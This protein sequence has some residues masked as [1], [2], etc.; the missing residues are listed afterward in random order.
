MISEL[1]RHNARLKGIGAYNEGLNFAQCPN[2]GF[3]P[4]DLEWRWEWQ[5]GWLRAQ[6]DEHD[7]KK[8]QPKT[9]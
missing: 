9:P 6:L 5:K 1:D 2:Q 4:D 8:P 7:R 3:Q